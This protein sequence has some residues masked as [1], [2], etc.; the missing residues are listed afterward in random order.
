MSPKSHPSLLLINCYLATSP[1][2]GLVFVIHKMRK[3]RPPVKLQRLYTKLGLAAP[4]GCGCP[5]HHRVSEDQTSQLESSG[6]TEEGAKPWSGQPP[7]PRIS[8]HWRP[9]PGSSPWH[10]QLAVGPP[11][12]PG[13]Q[14][15]RV[16]GLAVY[17]SHDAASVRLLN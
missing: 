12:F 4:R 15:S 9:G 3:P 1:A 7:R 8:T 16:S 11:G 10:H 14:G 17:G 5:D 6:E 2:R 13:S